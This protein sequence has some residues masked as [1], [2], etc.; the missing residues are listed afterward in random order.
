[1]GKKK[2]SGKSKAPKGRAGAKKKAQKGPSNGGF[3]GGPGFVRQM[4]GDDDGSGTVDLHRS[5]LC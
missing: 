5:F 4:L 2:G 3:G 1:M